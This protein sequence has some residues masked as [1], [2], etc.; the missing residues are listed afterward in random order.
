MPGEHLS[1][2]SQVG[3]HDT[4]PLDLTDVG[5]RIDASHRVRQV[6]CS[7]NT[8]R[9]SRFRS[10]NLN[11]GRRA[12]V[13]PIR[14]GRSHKFGPGS[15]TAVRF[16]SDNGCRIRSRARWTG[17]RQPGTCRIRRK[18]RLP[19][20]SS[21]YLIW[22]DRMPHIRL[23]TG[24]CDRSAWSGNNSRRSSRYRYCHTCRSESR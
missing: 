5:T 20:W 3:L 9:R 18:C 13:Q 23:E 16:R 15:R 7:T 6:D 24:R 22:L 17:T 12:T 14:I 1:I 11:S 21:N 8:V 10:S 2:V 19:G 4:C